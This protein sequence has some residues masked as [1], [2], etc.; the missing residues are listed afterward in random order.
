MLNFYSDSQMSGGRPSVSVNA[1]YG[2]LL[3]LALSIVPATVLCFLIILLR[4]NVLCGCPLSCDGFMCESY[5]MHGRF[6]YYAD[7][8]SISKVVVA[9]LTVYGLF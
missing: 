5:A 2:W 7:V 1:G 8:H 3:Y 9:I 6:L 4:I